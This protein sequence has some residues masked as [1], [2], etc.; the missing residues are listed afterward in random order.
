[1]KKLTVIFAIL[2]AV[3]MAAPVMAAEAV[4]DAD[5][6]GVADNKDKCPRTP[7]GQRVDKYGCSTDQTSARINSNEI[8]D[9]GMSTTLVDNQKGIR[10][11]L[12]Y[13]TNAT[14]NG[15]N[16][17][18][19]YDADV[20]NTIEIR[21]FSTFN[22]RGNEDAEGWVEY[23]NKNAK[24]FFFLCG[25]LGF[26][27]PANLIVGGLNYPVQREPVLGLAG[28]FYLGLPK[29]G[30]DFLVGP[31][32][33]ATTNMLVPGLRAEATERIGLTSSLGLVLRGEGEARFPSGMEDSY[34]GRGFI[35]LDLFR[36]VEFGPYIEGRNFA[37]S[38]N[39]NERADRTAIGGEVRIRPNG[40]DPGPELYLFC[41]A[42]PSR[43]RILNSNEC[44]AGIRLSW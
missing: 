33:H 16:S 32:V 28:G 42:D 12:E 41:G 22:G 10:K 21:G 36:T 6:D 39:D 24:K 1:M 17:R 44:G 11:I 23:C 3:F 9:T 14:A 18:S 40:K 7:A 15:S 37:W 43:N 38:Q 25:S 5:R 27:D 35:G 34:R 31:T 29:Y 2:M 20:T 4:P 26:R 13:L 30:L 19:G 8:T